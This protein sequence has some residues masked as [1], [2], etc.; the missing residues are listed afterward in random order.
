MPPTS[1]HPHPLSSIPGLTRQVF[2]GLR[3]R[4]G[5]NSGLE[6]CHITRN[7][8]SNRTMYSGRPL[9]H[10]K[11]TSDMAVVSDWPGRRATQAVGH[12]G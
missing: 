9:A 5:L 1:P 8:I 7:R 6:D 12:K 4:I 2:R 11:A 3:V 10:A